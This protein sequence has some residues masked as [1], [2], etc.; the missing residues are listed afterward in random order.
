MAKKVPTPKAPAKAAAPYKVAPAPKP[1]AAPKE[2]TAKRAAAKTTAKPAA[3]PAAK[4]AVKPA[5][6]PAAKASAKPGPGGKKEVR[7]YS[8][9]G[10]LTGG[11]SAKSGPRTIKTR[12]TGPSPE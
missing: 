4:S 12:G 5:A 2:A 6:K 10:K 9:G 8:S 7:S 1:S 11:T 3:K